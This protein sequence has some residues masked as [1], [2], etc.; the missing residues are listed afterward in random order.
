MEAVESPLI[1]AEPSA[2]PH[3]HTAQRF[4]IPFTKENSAEMARRAQVA[5][6]RRLQE[7]AARAEI[8]TISADDAAYRKFRLIRTREQLLGLDRD[9]EAC[10]DEKGKKAICDSIARLSD[11]E[12]KLAMRPL[13]GSRRPSREPSAKVPSTLEPTE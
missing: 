1:P 10:S 9:L 3:H 2:Q 5:R 4:G 8:E 11:V 6:K 12:Q 7:E 13:P